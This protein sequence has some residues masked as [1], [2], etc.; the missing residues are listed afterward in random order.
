MSYGNTGYLEMCN[1][2]MKL[3]KSKKVAAMTVRSREG[4][5]RD[6]DGARGGILGASESATAL[7]CR[8]GAPEAGSARPSFVQS[9]GRPFS[10]QCQDN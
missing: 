5:R 6:W 9:R 8:P 1:S 3:R 4:G 7:V 2:V 10:K